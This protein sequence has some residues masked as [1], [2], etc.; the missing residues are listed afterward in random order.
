VNIEL[1]LTNFVFCGPEDSFYSEILLEEIWF[2]LS[3]LDP[4]LTFDLLRLIDLYRLD[5]V[6]LE[7][8]FF[9]IVVFDFYNDMR[10]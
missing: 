10:C 1:V 6:A 4:M 2:E 8:W 5:F 9:L 3:W 7:T